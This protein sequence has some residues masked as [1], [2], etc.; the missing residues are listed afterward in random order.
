MLVERRRQ[1]L[2][3]GVGSEEAAQK[4]PEPSLEDAEG[5]LH[6]VRIGDVARLLGNGRRPPVRADG[7]QE[8]EKEDPDRAVG[9]REIF[10]SGFEVV[11]HWEPG[12]R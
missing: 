1:P 4:H 2:V 10:Q 11:L 7:P 5:A 3:A 12:G 6:R 9:K 8:R